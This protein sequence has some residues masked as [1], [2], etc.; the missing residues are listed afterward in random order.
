MA[1]VVAGKY[2]VGRMLGEGGM[3]A[4]YAAEH[5]E[6]GTTVAVKMMS[7]HC[8]A[9]PEALV[10]FKREAHALAAVRHENVVSVMDAGTDD[11]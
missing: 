6:L 11:G 5:T 1:R 3:G 2:R 7:D 9:A 10:R 4:V 8:M